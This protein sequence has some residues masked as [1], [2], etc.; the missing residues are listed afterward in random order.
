MLSS[1]QCVILNVPIMDTLLSL[2]PISVVSHQISIIKKMQNFVLF[3]PIITLK[4]EK[5]NNS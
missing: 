3:T 4:I 5:V 1:R 2:P